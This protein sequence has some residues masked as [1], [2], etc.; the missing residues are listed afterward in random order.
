[1]SIRIKIRLT[2]APDFLKGF[3]TTLD[4][5]ACWPQENIWQNPDT[6]LQKN[7]GYGPGSGIS[8]SSV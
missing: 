6:H 5:D 3:L 8:G 7:P 1:M 4:T 2:L